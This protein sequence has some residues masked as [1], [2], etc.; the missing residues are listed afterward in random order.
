MRRRGRLVALLPLV[1]EPNR[2]LALA[3]AGVSDYLDVLIDPAEEPLASQVIARVLAT[4][5]RPL[6]AHELR[7]T[8]FL[9]RAR[10][11]GAS[12]AIRE[13]P[14]PALALP[15]S[16]PLDE[17]VPPGFRRRLAYARRRAAR[18]GFRLET[19][20]SATLDE[21]LGALFRLHAARWGRRGQ[22]GVL[23]APAVE[24]F[25]R[26]AASALFRS[27]LLALHGL[28]D[29]AGALVAVSYGFRARDR[30]Y[31]YLSGFDPALSRY[32]PGALVVGHSIDEAYAAGARVCDFL[33]GAEPYKYDWGAIDDFTFGRSFGAPAGRSE[34]RWSPGP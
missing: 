3:G 18:E 24:D 22:A 16:G 31:L 8:S 23:A 25:H 17:V 30:A 15:A 26:D 32:S 2:A 19:A 21:Q 27:G 29:P 11:A 12:P 10:L 34:E 13:L 1:R 7:A 28:R 9:A 6:A 20:A 33:R 4:S 14:C 5:S